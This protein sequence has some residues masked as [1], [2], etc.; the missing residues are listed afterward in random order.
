[1]NLKLT[2]PILA[3]ATLAGCSTAPRVAS[4]DYD[5]KWVGVIECYERYGGGSA[6]SYITRRV[7]WQ[8]V[9]GQGKS[10]PDPVWQDWDVEFNG[11]QVTANARVADPRGQWAYEFK[12]QAVQ[13]RKFTATGYV[14]DGYNKSR[15]GRE[16]KLTGV[17]AKPSA[18]S[19]AGRP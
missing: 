15:I 17:L 8:V 11:G 16:C 3:L 5:G 10:L 19:I 13:P 7:E 12:G 4:T 9:N 6:P 1:M 14:Y 18:T 2:L